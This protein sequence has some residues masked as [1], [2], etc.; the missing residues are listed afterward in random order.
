MPDIISQWVSTVRDTGVTRHLPQHRLS[1]QVFFRHTAHTVTHHQDTDASD[2]HPAQHPTQ[3]H[4][5]DNSKKFVKWTQRMKCKFLCMCVGSIQYWVL[6]IVGGHSTFGHHI[7]TFGA[8]KWSDY[9]L[10]AWVVELNWFWE[11]TKENPRI[12]PRV[13][14]RPVRSYVYKH[15]KWM[16]YLRDATCQVHQQ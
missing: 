4:W 16:L 15:V 5:R 7:Y 8:I 12:R 6:L 14:K 13:T 11:R 2:W 1:F 3:T 9:Y 10:E